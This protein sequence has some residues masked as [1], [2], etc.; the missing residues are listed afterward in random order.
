MAAITFPRPGLLRLPH[1]QAP[2]PGTA[3]RPSPGAL[4]RTLA[5]RL[6]GQPHAGPVARAWHRR[7]PEQLPDIEPAP[8][9]LRSSPPNAGLRRLSRPA[10]HGYAS[11]LALRSRVRLPL[12]VG[13]G[14]RAEH[15]G[16]GE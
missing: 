1:P 6:Q 14:L 13:T 2:V 9:Q 10:H 15:A 3:L 12:R 16:S 4:S 5:D 8:A 7:L 11:R